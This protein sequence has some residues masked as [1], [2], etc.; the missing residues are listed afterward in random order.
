MGAMAIIIGTSGYDYPDWV[1]QDRFYPASLAKQRPDWLTYYASRFA[2]IELNYTFYGKASPAQLSQ[3]LR[4]VEP[5]RSLWLL[6]GQYQPRADFGFVIKAYAELTHRIDTDWRHQA[7][8]FAHDISPLSES[9]KLLGVLAQFPS[10]AHYSVEF[11]QYVVALAHELQPLPLIA[12]FRHL[13]WYDADVRAQLREAGIV[14]A[15]VDAPHAAQLPTILG[16][17]PDLQPDTGADTTLPAGVASES[18]I[19]LHGRNEATWW[20]GDAVTRYDY[21]Y[22]DTQL[23]RLA[24]RL[25]C[26]DSDR[27][28]V[29]FNNHRF[30]EAPR[31][32]IK[33]QE[34][35]TRLAADLNVEKRDL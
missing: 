22:S 29:S 13:Q 20:T 26:A 3:M 23:E 27:I 19:R 8:A 10:S 2:F 5:A 12:E 21:R 35:M 18:Y 24:Q 9:G 15:G 4:R 32:A 25:L 1:G 28:H 30:A 11:A 34:L 17:Y 7:R 16:D 33:L 6:E 31:N 14:V